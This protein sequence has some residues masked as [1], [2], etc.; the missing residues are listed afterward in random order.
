MKPL[1][2]TSLGL[3]PMSLITHLRPSMAPALGRG[4]ESIRRL[5]S[6][7]PHQGQSHREQQLL[8]LR[9]LVSGA[10]TVRSVLCSTQPVH[11]T[12]VR[13]LTSTIKSKKK[14]TKLR[15][16]M[17][18]LGRSRIVGPECVENDKRI[19]G[20]LILLL[21]IV[22]ICT[23]DTGR[24]GRHHSE[25]LQRRRPQARSRRSRRSRQWLGQ[26]WSS[27]QSSAKRH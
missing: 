11:A 16:L 25:L 7:L 8:Q 22:E 1:L 2:R 10:R 18:R 3:H 12:S 24:I 9:Q 26:G 19:P 21:S 13:N 6:L 20:L 17:Y 23:N 5:L 14:S 15:C 4:M 27:K